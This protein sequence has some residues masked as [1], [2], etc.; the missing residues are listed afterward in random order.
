[1]GEQQTKFAT[2]L[3]DEKKAAQKA[4]KLTVFLTGAFRLIFDY[5]CGK[6]NARRGK[7][8]GERAAGPEA[9]A[10]YGDGGKRGQKRRGGPV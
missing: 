4:K 9:G 5:F 2:S 1:M 8:W 7:A 3:S 10:V 6:E